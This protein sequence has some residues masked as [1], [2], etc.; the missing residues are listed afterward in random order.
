[1]PAAAHGSAPGPAGGSSLARLASG[2]EDAAAWPPPGGTPPPLPSSAAPARLGRASRLGGRGACVGGVVPPLAA[3]HGPA[4]PASR[5]AS[6]PIGN[7][8]IAV[9]VAGPGLAAAA[10]SAAVQEAAA[11]GARASSAAAARGRGAREASGAAPLSSRATTSRLMSSSLLKGRSMREPRKATTV[12]ALQPRWRRRC[13]QTGR[14]SSEAAKQRSRGQ[15]FPRVRN[16][17]RWAPGVPSNSET[18]VTHGGAETPL[19]HPNIDTAMLAPKWEGTRNIEEPLYPYNRGC[20]VSFFLI[21]A[22]KST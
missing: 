11:G 8:S 16:S 18:S 19:M 15:R 10:G 5:P 13:L 3:G 17:P 2:V 7:M 22:S 4:A 9:T 12:S 6:R 14:R 21:P 1:M 20:H